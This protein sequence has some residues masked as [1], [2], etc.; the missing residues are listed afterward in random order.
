MQ[1]SGADEPMI[2]FAGEDGFGIEDVPLREVV[3]LK[4]L[5]GKGTRHRDQQKRKHWR[6]VHGFAIWPRLRLFSREDCPA[7]RGNLRA[8]ALLIQSKFRMTLSRVWRRGPGQRA[9]RK[10]N[11]IFY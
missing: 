7:T 1:K 4:A 5:V 8:I 2:L 9:V 10:K 11:F 6:V 3:A